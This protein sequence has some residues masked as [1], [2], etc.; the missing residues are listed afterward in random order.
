MTDDNEDHVNQAKDGEHAHEAGG[1]HSPPNDLK[2]KADGKSDDYESGFAHPRGF[3]VLRIDDELLRDLANWRKN[4]QD[5]K[6]F[7]RRRL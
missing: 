1:S 6:L 3:V 2:N 5:S 7:F 4:G